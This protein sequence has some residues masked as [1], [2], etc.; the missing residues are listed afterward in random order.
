MRAPFYRVEPG[1]KVRLQKLDP[2]NTGPFAHREDAAEATAADLERLRALQEQFFVDGR[3][4]LLLVLQGM[5]TSGKDGTIGHLS[6][7][8][9]L[10]GAEVAS[11]KAPTDDE[12]DHDFLWRIHQK[13]PARRRI[14]IFNRSQYEDVLIV[15]VRKLVPEGVWRG[16]YEQINQFEQILTQNNTIILKCFLHISKDE[17]KERLLARLDE[18]D[19]LWKLQPDDLA[20]R[21]LWKDYQKAYEAAIANCSTDWAPWYIIPANH[22]WYRNYAV[23]RL[24]VETLEGLDLKL[25]RPTIDQKSIRIE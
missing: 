25:P 12:L 4:A 13:V 9:N 3:Y 17:Q 10:A 5:D 20:S 14:G 16:R 15:R 23:T 6:A 22:K 11:F 21:A 2:G 8:I 24:I 19:K 1:S 18:P 7:A